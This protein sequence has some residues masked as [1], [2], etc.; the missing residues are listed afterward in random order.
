MLGPSPCELPHAEMRGAG[1]HVSW[2][3]DKAEKACLQRKLQPLALP[4]HATDGRAAVELD[5]FVPPQRLARPRTA[6]RASAL[7]VVSFPARLQLRAPGEAP[8]PVGPFSGPGSLV[9]PLDTQ[10]AVKE[11]VSACA[12]GKAEINDGTCLTAWT[13]PE[14]R[15]PDLEPLTARRIDRTLAVEPI[16]LVAERQGG[17]QE[18]PI[19]YGEGFRLRAAG[20][21]ALYLG[22][23]GLGSCWKSGSD[24]IPPKGTRFSAHGGELGAPLHFGRPVSLRRVLSPPPSEVDSDPEFSDDDAERPDSEESS[25]E[26]GISAQGDTPM[27]QHGPCWMVNRCE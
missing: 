15:S 3:R 12:E 5:T 8:G 27:V 23:E 18:G 26:M 21:K 4:A 11:L 10:D 25:K 20:T 19:R 6:E 9:L 24:R 1:L 7:A 2:P 22:F 17:S 14:G 13:L 16:E